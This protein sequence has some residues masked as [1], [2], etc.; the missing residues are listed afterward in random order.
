MVIAKLHCRLR[1]PEPTGQTLVYPRSK[2]MHKDVRSA[3]QKGLKAPAHINRLA[4]K[5][6]VKGG[7]FGMDRSYHW[8]R[9]NP[10][11]FLN[12][13][14]DQQRQ[15]VDHLIHWENK[16]Y[17]APSK[18]RAPTLES[19]IRSKQP[20][21]IVPT[22]SLALVKGCVLDARLR[23]R[24]FGHDTSQELLSQA[25][26]RTAKYPWSNVEL[27]VEVGDHG[28]LPVRRPLSSS[29]A[30]ISGPYRTSPAGD[31]TWRS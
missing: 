28:S 9:H 19:G 23:F 15:A 25:S 2:C 24:G 11:S 13:T 12:F 20:Y 3:I 29:T 21:I 16:L 22:R 8:S 17:C 26:A 7:T 6:R 10:P 14:I 18:N 5:A 30:S 1:E 4:Q 31:F 27:S